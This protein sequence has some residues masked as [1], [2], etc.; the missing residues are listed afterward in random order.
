[1]KRT[2][3]QLEHTEEFKSAVESCKTKR[4]AAGK[5]PENCF[6]IVTSS[7]KSAGKPIFVKQRDPEM[8]KQGLVERDIR[9]YVEFER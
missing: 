2:V 5:N 1:V 4:K 6:A 7:F 3:E 8:V 9:I